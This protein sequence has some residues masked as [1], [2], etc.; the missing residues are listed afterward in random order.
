MKPIDFQGQTILITGATRGIGKQIADDLSDFGANLILTGTRQEEIDFLNADAN[1]NNKKRQYYCLNILSK[2]SL[3]QFIEQISKFERIDGLVN[4]VGINRLNAINN[5]LE[6]DWEDMVAVN[7]SAPFKI[8][9][10]VSSKMIS[11]E[12]GRIIN[13]SSIFGKI[14][15]ER[16]VVY[17]ATKFG[18]H[19]LTVG[20]SNDLARYNIM[21]NTVS[22]GFVLT[23]LTRKNLSEKEMNDLAE[24]VPSKRLASV[25]DISSFVVFLLS[26]LNQYMTGQNLIIDGGFTNV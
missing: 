17:S 6:N 10:A 24:Q 11:Q 4:N 20:A 26:E 15:K 13:I 2:E 8:L 18:L 5:V 21:V 25:T 7:L 22:P 9:K 19:G 14:S 1:L 12:Y 23:D 16:R 3:D